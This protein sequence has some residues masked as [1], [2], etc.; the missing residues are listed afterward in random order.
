MGD[1]QP[2]PPFRGPPLFPWKTVH[3][4]FPCLPSGWGARVQERIAD[5]KG[6]V[7]RSKGTATRE[8]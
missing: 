6:E 5:L 1:L 4:N 7:P 8:D 2:G 3:F